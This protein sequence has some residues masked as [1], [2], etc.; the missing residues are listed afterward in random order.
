MD[1]DSRVRSIYEYM[2]NV[3][4]LSPEEIRLLKNAVHLLHEISPV[5]R[6]LIFKKMDD[7]ISAS[8]DLSWLVLVLKRNLD[9][10]KRKISDIKSPA[11]TMLVRQGRPSTVAIEHEI[12]FSN[13]QLPDLEDKEKIVEN[14]LEYVVYVQKCLGDYSWVLID[15]LKSD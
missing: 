4:E 1:I 5:D 8:D 11:F 15:K 2:L 7:I 3:V 12:R 10:I 14:I 6:P 13:K 9:S